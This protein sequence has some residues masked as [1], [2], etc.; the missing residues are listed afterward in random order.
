MTIDK[1]WLSARHE[2]TT[3]GRAEMSRR[4]KDC[5]ANIALAFSYLPI[6]NSVSS[7]GTFDFEEVG[8]H[9]GCKSQRK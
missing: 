8:I 5:T 3:I 1:S 6:G 7:L 9:V 2:S 4:L